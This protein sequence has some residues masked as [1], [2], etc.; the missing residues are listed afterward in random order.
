MGVQALAGSLADQNPAFVVQPHH[1]RGQHLTQ[2]VRH[3]HTGVVMPDSHQ[4]VGGTQ[5]D[6]DNHLCVPFPWLDFMDLFFL[7]PQRQIV[8]IVRSRFAMKVQCQTSRR[9]SSSAP[10]LVLKSSA[11][12]EDTAKA[13]RF[14]PHEGSMTDC[15]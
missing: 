9:G 10:Q 7:E 2:G 13:A 3:Q 6:S 4:A 15:F 14:A 5:V 11:R 1:R 12:P 8:V